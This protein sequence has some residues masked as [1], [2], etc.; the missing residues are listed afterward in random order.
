ML[1]SQK[2]FT[3]RIYTLTRQI[4]KG[5]VA[6]YSQLAQLAGSPNAARAVGMM[7]KINPDAPHTPCHRVVSS[8]GELVGYSAYGGIEQKKKLLIEEG[9][10]FDNNKVNL[11]LSKW[12]PDKNSLVGM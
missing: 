12:E 2:L 11:S 9:V 7:M 4:P 8:G 3:Q 6:T 1:V 5:K 10:Y